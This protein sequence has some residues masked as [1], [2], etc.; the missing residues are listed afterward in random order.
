M[1]YTL[2]EVL[3]NYEISEENYKEIYRYLS[4][5]ELDYHNGQDLSEYSSNSYE[6]FVA[7]V[8]GDKYNHY[9]AEDIAVEL[10]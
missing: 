2:Q 4:N 1:H 3:D 6:I 9:M 7:Q 5:L 8:I 10:Y